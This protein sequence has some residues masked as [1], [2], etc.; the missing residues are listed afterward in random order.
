MGYYAGFR[1]VFGPLVRRKIRTVRGTEYL[2]L[3][4]PFIVAGNHVGFID[5]LALAMLN[6]NR[7]RRPTYYLTT[8]WVWKFFGEWLA[9]NVLGMIPL[10]DVQGS[11]LADSLGEAVATLRSGEIVGIFPEA[12]RNPK[13]DELLRGKTGAVR[14]ALATGAPLIPVGVVNNTGYDF[15][16]AMLSLLRPKTGIDLTFGQPVDLSEFRGQPVD[17]PLLEAATRKLMLAI[18]SLCGKKYVF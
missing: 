7:Y 17:K 10:L 1:Q 13:P 2:P 12:H 4:P 18:S 3:Q 8:Q 5:A 11:R 6:Y 16:A 15:S 9:R 14:M